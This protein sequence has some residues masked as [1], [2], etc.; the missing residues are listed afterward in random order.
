[1]KKL[2]PYTRNLKLKCTSKF[3]H[4]RA[5]GTDT[6]SIAKQKSSKSKRSQLPF[7]EAL[8]KKTEKEV[9]LKQEM[10][11]NAQQELEEKYR[12]ERAQLEANKNVQRS[13]QWLQNEADSEPGIDHLQQ[14]SVGNDGSML[15]NLS[16]AAIP[17]Y[18]THEI[19]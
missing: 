6:V 8:K 17:L 16:T 11:M 5:E 10:I 3:I 18:T 1:M 9:K 2:R 13:Q 7:T 15:R 12:A 14:N 19:N 4:N